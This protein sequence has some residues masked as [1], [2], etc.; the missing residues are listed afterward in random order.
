[1]LRTESLRRAFDTWYWGRKSISN[2]DRVF[3]YLACF[4]MGLAWGIL[5][6]WRG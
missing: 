4:L 3:N 5:L 1:M 2:H 6:S